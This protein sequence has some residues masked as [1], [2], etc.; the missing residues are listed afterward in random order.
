MTAPRL[1]ERVSER[2]HVLGPERAPVTVVEY[3]DFQC[4]HSARAHLLLQELREAVGDKMR[5]VYRHLP[6]TQLHPY[7]AQAAEAAEVAGAHGKFWQMHD[8]LFDNQRHLKIANLREY[9]QRL[10]LDMPRFIAEMD[11][12]IYLQRVREHM[13]GGTRSHVRGTPTFFINGVIHDVSFGMHALMEGV[14]AAL[15]RID[16]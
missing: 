5:L 4:P 11:D 7:A 12:E 13:Q 16:R 14:E 10:E 1:A 3:A 9:A 8:L 15:R 6:L 2:D